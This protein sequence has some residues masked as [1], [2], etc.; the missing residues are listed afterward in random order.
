MEVLIIFGKLV[1]CI[2]GGFASV[3]AML[4]AV[5]YA[6]RLFAWIV[7]SDEAWKAML[8]KEKDES[9]NDSSER[10]YAQ[11]RDEGLNIGWDLTPS[12]IESWKNSNGS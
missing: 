1:L 5:A 12:Q 6:A 4:F 8:Q 3:I 9:N 11:Y 7:L 10:G 2:V